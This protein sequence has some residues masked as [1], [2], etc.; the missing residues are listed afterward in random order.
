MSYQ[1]NF[2]NEVVSLIR[3]DGF[4]CEEALPTIGIVALFNE[5][6]IGYIGASR[7]Y[8][9]NAF[10]SIVIVHPAA[11]GLGVGLSL[12]K[13][14]LNEFKRLGIK[15]FEAHTEEDNITA[16]KIYAELG[17]ELRKVWLLEGETDD[18]IRNI[19]D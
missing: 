7:T 16:L 17:L 9:N 3:D 19:K 1:K 18:I 15:K 14:M 11:R 6:V 12:M 2:L 10:V 5:Q 13:E 8:N 4:D